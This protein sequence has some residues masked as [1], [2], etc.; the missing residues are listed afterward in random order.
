MKQSRSQV[1]FKYTKALYEVAEENDELETIISE[2][3]ALDIVFKEN[4]NLVKALSKN[5]ISL[6]E[7]I[8][9]LDTLKSQ[10]SSI[11]QDFLSLLS[12]YNRLDTLPIIIDDFIKLHDE[13]MGII[14]A[15]VITTYDLKDSQLEA[16]KKS[17]QKRFNAK[18]VRI[19]NKIDD[20]IMGGAVVRVGDQII[21][22]SIQRKLA[23]VKRLLLE[24]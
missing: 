19:E 22:G 12:D 2:I 5:S 14:E 3:E 18:E 15:T 6:S 8:G 4:T 16:F 11:M 21:D 13:K 20:S 1:A 23:D 9:L 10:L 7:R 24:K 17:L